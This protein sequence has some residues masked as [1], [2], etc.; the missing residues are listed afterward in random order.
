MSPN[1][2][3]I[4]QAVRQQYASKA[5]DG[6]CCGPSTCC[7]P[8]ASLFYP[9]DLLTNLPA[10]V[11]SFSLGCGD[12]I[13]LAQLQP[14][15]TVLDLG[16]GG[17][18]DCFL[19]A[20]LVG[21]SGHVIG[22]DM[23]PEMIQRARSAAERLGIPQ[24]EFRLGLLEQLPL[25]DESVDV[26]ISNCVINLVPDKLKVFAEMFRVLKAGGRVAVADIVSNGP[27]PQALRE[28]FQAWSECL[29]GALEI[30]EY[31]RGLIGV[32]FTEV[33]ITPKGDLSN[34]ASKLPVGVPFSAT[35]TARKSA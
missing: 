23:T 35:I 21:E 28:N 33:T 11:A 5:R 15:E 20:Q 1:P 6:S 10:D 26:I 14:G 9:D 19:A 4:R 31:V 24:V 18:L 25:D 27:L 16:S 29:G 2:D 34:L 13:S 17:G 8:Q 7:D 32:G 30:Q 12:P 3:E 22:V